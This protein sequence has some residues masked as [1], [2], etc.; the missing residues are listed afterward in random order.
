MLVYKN[1]KYGFTLRFPTRWRTH[2]VVSRRKRVAETEYELHFKFRYNRKI[3]DNVLSILVY[4]MT[5]EQWYEQGYSE[6]PLSLLGVSNGRLFA[7][8]TP[9]ELPS[10]F[11][12][13]KTGEYNYKRYG[14]AIKL[15]RQMVNKDVPRIMESI[16][17]PA[18]A[19]KL[20]TTP[21]YGKSVCGCAGR[22][23]LRRKKRTR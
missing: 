2:C 16:R 12:D 22:G 20:R 19:R 9:E 5:E 14:A 15:L 10:E 17:F 4:R 13:P 1:D 23:V 8:Q 3:Y 11:V 7:C 6:S 21:Y 18:A